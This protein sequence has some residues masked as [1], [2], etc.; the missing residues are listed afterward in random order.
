MKN[1]WLISEN[2]IEEGRSGKMTRGASFEERKIRRSMNEDF[3][4]LRGANSVASRQRITFRLK[5]NIERLLIVRMRDC[6]R[7]H[8]R[9]IWKNIKDTNYRIEERR[10]LNGRK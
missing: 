8:S 10:L 6:A 7:T 9:K 4:R 3:N 5:E 1:I 2:I